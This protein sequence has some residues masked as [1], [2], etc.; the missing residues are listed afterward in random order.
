MLGKG[1]LFQ[2]LFFSF[3]ELV[4]INT[5][6]IE[7]SVPYLTIGVS[8][9]NSSFFSSERVILQTTCC[10]I[11]SD[12]S[13]LLALGHSMMDILSHANDLISRVPISFSSLGNHEELVD[14]IFLLF[15]LRILEKNNFLFLNTII[16]TGDRRRII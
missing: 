10:I 2:T 8:T 5:M 12:L 3:L 9:S 1:T 13:F 11:K 4:S 6:K 14:E 15:F 7:S 16:E